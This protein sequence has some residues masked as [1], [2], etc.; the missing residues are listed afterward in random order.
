MIRNV[1]A[2]LDMT[3]IEADLTDA[4]K[5]APIANNVVL[6]IMIDP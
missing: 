4:D 5:S 2:S 3:K 6:F 1:S